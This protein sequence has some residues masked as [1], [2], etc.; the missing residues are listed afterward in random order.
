MNILIIAVGKCKEA[1]I[2][3]GIAEYRKRLTKQGSVEI[4]EVK[5]EKTPE[6]ASE[7]EKEQVKETEGARILK[8]VP[9]RGYVIALEP[10][11]RMISSEQLAATFHESAVQGTSTIIFVIG[12]SLGLSEEVLKRADFKWS[13]SKL[14]FPHQ[15]IRL[16]LTEQIYRAVQI[17]AGSP[18]HK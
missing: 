10:E 12:G 18:Y 3:E 8:K 16:M 5:D 6:Q 1:F 14:T 7:K 9:E 11:G 2:N 17:N 13:F 4:V 15:L